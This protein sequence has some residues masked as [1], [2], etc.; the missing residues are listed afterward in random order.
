MGTEF[1][2]LEKKTVIKALNRLVN[3]INYSLAIHKEFGNY[4]NTNEEATNAARELG[5]AERLL[6]VLN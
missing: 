2:D 4:Y 3:D 1:N 6:K 5:V